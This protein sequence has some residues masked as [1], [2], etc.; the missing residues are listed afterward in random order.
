MEI[1]QHTKTEI[2]IINFHIYLDLI[3]TASSFPLHSISDFQV[4]F[5]Y[6]NATGLCHDD[7]YDDDDELDRFS[8]TKDGV[9]KKKLRKNEYLDNYVESFQQKVSTSAFEFPL[10]ISQAFFVSYYEGSA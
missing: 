9:A 8:Q 6:L 7:S 10:F 5:P 1:G 2:C 3:V 4:F